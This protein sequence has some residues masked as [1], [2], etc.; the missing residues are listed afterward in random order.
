MKKIAEVDNERGFA[1]VLALVFMLS[2]TIIGVSVI[3]N[4][5]T[6]MH[7]ASNEKDA[8]V[9][10]QVSEAGFQEA[11]G[12]IHLATSSALYAGE[13]AGL[14]Y[15]SRK[16]DPTWSNTFTSSE[17]DLD[18]TVTISYLLEYENPGDPDSEHDFCDKNAEG[19]WN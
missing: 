4:M 15:A 13:P 17:A 11:L 6:E 7:I 1:L 14:D 8:K 16:A 9:A 18:Y 19:G 10:F 2:M 12:R 5:S 3:T